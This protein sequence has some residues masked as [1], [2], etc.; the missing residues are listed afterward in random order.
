MGGWEAEITDVAMQKLILLAKWKDLN[1]KP[2]D[3]PDKAASKD[4][5]PPERL[6]D[7]I[8]QQV[9]WVERMA[10]KCGFSGHL[11]DQVTPEQSGEQPTDQPTEKPTSEH[12]PATEIMVD[13][14]TDDPSVES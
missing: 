7:F 9:K 2:S 12:P 6:Q 8:R 3:N 1:M 14:P 13:E 5:S 4:S 11:K 10:K